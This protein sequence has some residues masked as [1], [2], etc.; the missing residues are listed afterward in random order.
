MMPQEASEHSLPASH[1]LFESSSEGSFLAPGIS[2]VSSGLWLQSNEQRTQGGLVL[3]SPKGENDPQRKSLV[4][5]SI[6][7]GM[8]NHAALVGCVGG[9]WVLPDAAG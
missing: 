9:K 4:H 7:V 8:P 1:G 5:R 2:D 6:D 3:R